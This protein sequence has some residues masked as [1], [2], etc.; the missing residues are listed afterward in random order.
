MNLH[1]FAI[2]LTLQSILTLQGTPDPTSLCQGNTDSSP[3]CSSCFS[4]AT[5]II[6][7]RSLSSNGLCTTILKNKV[8]NCKYYSGQ[9]L[10][11]HKVPRVG[12]CEICSA[13]FLTYMKA[14]NFAECTDVT[15]DCV[16]VENCLTTVCH[17][18]KDREMIKYK[19]TEKNMITLKEKEVELGT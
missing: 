18:N 5:S 2:F 3:L 14:E 13:L 15:N 10:V 9:T 11:D 4:D 12:T 16:Q 1:L 17:I 7:P 6:Q 8:T 19:R